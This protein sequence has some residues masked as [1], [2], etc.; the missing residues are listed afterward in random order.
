M[1]SFNALLISC[2]FMGSSFFAEVAICSED[3]TAFTQSG[4]TVILKKN[5]T[6]TFKKEKKEA[7]SI[8][9]VGVSEVQQRGEYCAIKFEVKNQTVLN[10]KSF[11][12]DTHLVDSNGNRFGTSN[13]QIAI[14]PNQNSITE[15]TYYRSACAEVAKIEI[16]S[17]R[18]CD[19]YDVGGK[20]IRAKDCITLLE[21]LS[22]TKIPIS[23]ISQK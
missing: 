19:V 4:E 10:F 7:A 11:W 2:L 20:V 17:F 22:G 13:I 1:S 3:I 5:G 16:D 23:V 6:W 8:I 18:A 14:R 9:K 21:P 15:V 12:P